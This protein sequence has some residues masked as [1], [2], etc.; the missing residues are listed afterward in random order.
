MSGQPD[1]YRFVPTADADNETP[2]IYS[3]VD[4]VSIRRIADL[5]EE[6]SDSFADRAFTAVEQRYC[7]RQRHPSQH[8]AARWA[9][10]EAF[11]KVLGESSPSVPTREIEVVRDP[12]GPRLSLGPSARE[13]LSA[14]LSEI[15]VATRQASYSVSLSHDLESD[16]AVAQVVVVTAGKDLPD[17]GDRS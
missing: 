15:G 2:T 13:A 5:L 1:H 7:D 8:Y 12:S 14:R 4:V 3:G 6:F 9:A 16:A 10:K 11:L 17:R